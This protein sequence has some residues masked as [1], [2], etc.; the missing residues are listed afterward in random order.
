MDKRMIGILGGGQL[1]RM[2]IEAANRL[3]ISVAVLDTAGNPA[4]QISSVAPHVDGTFKDA[5]RIMELAKQCNNLTVEIEHVNCD[6]LE[7]AEKELGISVQPTPATIRVIQDKY[8]QKVHLAKHSV[9]L[10]EFAEVEPGNEVASI[11][12]TAVGFGFPLMLKSKTLAYD[13]RGNRVVK[14]EADVEAA[15]NDL[16]GGQQKNGPQLYVEKW[17]S[18][19]KELAVMVARGLDGAILSYPCVETVQKDNI[20]HLV[21]APAQIDGLVARNARDIAEQAI[22]SLPG[23]G[24]FGVEMFLLDDGSIVLNEIAPRPHN[25]GHYTIEACHTSQFEQHLRC[26]LGL[27]LGSTEMKVPASVMVNILGLGDGDA[28]MDETLKPCVAAMA[29]KG[30]T[31]HL[32]GKGSCRKG[33]KMGHVTIVGETMPEVFKAVDEML[34]LMPGTEKSSVLSVRPVVGIIM[35]S[36]SD[37]PTLKAAATILKDFGVPF[38]L[39]IVS[40]HRTPL[41]MVNY[42]KTAHERGIKVIIAAAGGAAHLPGMVAALTPLPVIGV[43]VALRVLDGMDSLYSIVQMPRGIPVAT[44]AINNST[45]AAL[46]AVRI[47]G[48]DTPVYLKRMEAYMKKQE[49][50]VLTK[51]ETLESVGWEKYE[52]KH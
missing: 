6:A 25:S 20:C 49:A 7:R 38:E 11:K 52:V 9:P 30:A 23:A 28:G 32:Y 42:A 24:V 8:V 45:N 33:R 46:L 26:I 3:N 48:A 13:G 34:A 12:S 15:V 39:S 44:V 2:T 18:F 40:A 27:P 5:D 51:I 1:G 43:P 47:L 41:R 35:G 14:N 21:I 37:L 4:A 31:I 17:V 22:A 29:L 36:D 50:E 19:K 10:P 16:G